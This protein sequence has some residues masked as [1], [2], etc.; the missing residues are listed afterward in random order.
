MND[1]GS[2]SVVA[3]SAGILGFTA[4]LPQVRVAVDPLGG[5]GIPLPRGIG[6][7]LAQGTHNHWRSFLKTVPDFITNLTRWSSVMSLRGSPETATKSAHFPASMV[8]IL[9]D[10][11]RSSAAVVVVQNG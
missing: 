2:F 6:W 11:P 4:G 7:K 3:D 10:Q 8:P 1:L 9:S 5:I